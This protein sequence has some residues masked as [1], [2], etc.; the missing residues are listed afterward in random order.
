MEELDKK[1]VLKL[2]I[3]EVH[4]IEIRL[5]RVATRLSEMGLSTSAQA[6]L[7][8]SEELQAERSF[9]GKVQTRWG[10]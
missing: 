7:N 3:Q 9:L 8:T 5:N 10:A 2:T 6:I 4:E 1:D